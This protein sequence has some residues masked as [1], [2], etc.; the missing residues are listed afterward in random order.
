MNADPRGH[1]FVKKGVEY[2]LPA[3]FSDVSE[4]SGLDGFMFGGDWHV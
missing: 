4:D 2:I 3:D 1:Q